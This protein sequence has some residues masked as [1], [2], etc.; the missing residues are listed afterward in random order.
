MD[1]WQHQLE[2][3]VV[4]CDGALEINTDVIVQDVEC[5]RAVGSIEM[6][7][8]GRGGGCAMGVVLGGKGPDKDGGVEVIVNCY[9]DILVATA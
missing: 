6:V 5:G 1:M 7:V 9:H 4:S 3:A 8:E 2:G